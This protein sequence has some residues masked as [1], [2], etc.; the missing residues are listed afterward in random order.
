MGGNNSQP[1]NKDTLD[2]LQSLRS[3]LEETERTLAAERE[4]HGR[5]EAKFQDGK[6]TYEQMLA[7]LNE[8]RASTSTQADKDRAL[9][10]E[11]ELRR[12]IEADYQSGKKSYD[13]VVSQLT[14]C[15]A[16]TRTQTD[17][18]KALA[19]EREARIAAEAQYEASRRS[20]EDTTMQ[21]KECRT[22]CMDPKQVAV[23]RQQLSECQTRLAP[24]A[25]VGYSAPTDAFAAATQRTWPRL[26]TWAGQY[27]GMYDPRSGSHWISQGVNKPVLSAKMQTV[28]ERTMMVQFED[29][30]DRS[31]TFRL[32]AS[33]YILPYTTPLVGTVGPMVKGDLTTTDRS[34]ALGQDSTSTIGLAVTRD[35]YVGVGADNIL[36]ILPDPRRWQL[37]SLLEGIVLWTS[38]AQGK[39]CTLLYHNAPVTATGT[40]NPASLVSGLSPKQGGDWSVLGLSE[41][42]PD[43][44]VGQ[45][46]VWSF[47]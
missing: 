12:K 10:E 13:D 1:A 21:L 3:T 33:S 4:A 37:V 28:G 15:R 35:G 19:K 20:Y 16:S 29:F 9:A 47:R 43:P 8:C 24:P 32:A 2:Q 6:R 25:P 14:A 39:P 27:F 23:L 46:I 18:D 38:N 40:V 5:T 45:M 11:R 31:Y 30:D 26:K 17:S 22:A 44:T 7:N 36:S 34:W 42:R 41:E